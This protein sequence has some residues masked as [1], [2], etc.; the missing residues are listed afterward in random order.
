MALL[1]AGLL[2]QPMWLAAQDGRLIQAA[3]QGLPLRTGPGYFPNPLSPYHPMQVGAVNMSNSDRINRLIVGGNIMLSLSDAIALALENNLDIAIQRDNPKIA[4]LDILR[5]KAGTAARGVRT[6]VTSASTSAT[7]AAGAQGGTGTTTGGVGQGAGGQTTS[8][9]GAGS[10]IGNF[11]PMVSVNLGL[12]HAFNPVAGFQYITLGG[13]TTPFS[14]FTTAARNSGTANFN[15]SQAFHTG[16]SLNLAWNNSRTT[17]S[18]LAALS[19]QII[20][21]YTL[22]LTQHLLQGWG[23]ATNTR[24]IVIARN[25]REVS[26][27]VFKQ[28]VMLT[29]TQ[30][31]NM[32]W[33]LVS[34]GEDVKVKEQALKVAQRLYEDNKR[35]VEIGTL[36]QIEIVRAQAEVAARQQDLIVSQ[37]ALQQSETSMKN[38]ILKN[39][40]DPVIVSARVVPTDRITVPPVEPVVPIQ[41]LTATALSSRPELAE[42]RIDLRN[43]DISFKSVKNA[44]MPSLDAVGTWGGSGLSGQPPKGSAAAKNVIGGIG[45]TL[46][47]AFLAS[48][49]TY[50]VGLSLNVPIRNRSAQADAAQAQFENRQAKLRLA[51]LENSVRIEVQNAVIGLQQN[52]ARLEA[53]RSARTLQEQA[54]DAE[55]KKFNL[56]ASTIYLVIQ[57]QRDLATAQSAEVA[58]LGAY[59]KARVEMDRAT[60]QTITKNGIILEEAYQG[61]VSKPP[62]ALPTSRQNSED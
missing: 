3:E 55:Q 34:A 46:S 52:R 61:Q 41:E 44:L 39:L 42:S 8:T 31:Q 1:L 49:P 19:P 60:G 7:S 5:T 15:Y 50:F 22:Q 6:S 48:Y 21:N 26:D 54:L 29:V 40:T 62:Q 20:T 18:T 23:L 28:Q 13:V 11:D 12:Q 35:Q 47:Q 16:T 27:L 58:A 59:M 53:A 32:Y 4:D 24:N 30:V 25:N 2:V 17:N 56:G 45:D 51:Q 9:L 37:T 10:T 14:Y 43:R 33:D 57:A 36:A 38:I